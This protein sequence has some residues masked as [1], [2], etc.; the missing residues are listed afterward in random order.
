MRICFV[1]DD[2]TQLEYLKKLIEEWTSRNN[3]NTDIS[4]YHSSEEMLFENEGSYPF[5]MIILDIQMGDMNGIQLAK[6]IRETDSK[7]ILAF[8]SGADDYV[9]EGYEVQAI[10]YLLKPVK[11]EKIYDLLDYSK[12]RTEKKS[13]FLIL[14]L[15]GEKVKIDH[16]SIIY[17]ESMGHKILLNLTSGTHEYKYN[18][19]DLCNELPESKFI[20]THR[21]YVIN[22]RYIR[23]IKR[24]ECVLENGIR[25]PLS[26]NSYKEVNEK[27]INY[28]RG[29]VN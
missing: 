7:V 15:S 21:S 12:S 8:I 9:F 17:F 18:I 29:Q 13:E 6:K 28:L 1:D 23:K 10:R 11:E 3:E 22:I 5:D 25:V 20:R 24:N 16:D 4:F 19:R 26:R 27:F 2:A 14:S